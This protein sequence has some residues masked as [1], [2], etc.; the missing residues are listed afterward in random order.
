MIIRK[1]GLRS[2]ANIV[3]SVYVVIGL[4]AGAALTFVGLAG[5]AP[6]DLG[7]I[8]R[9]VFSPVAIFVLPIVSGIKGYIVGA[10]AAWVFN[11]V[12]PLAGGLEIEVE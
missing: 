6:S 11:R 1:V 7:G 10:L 5:L 12:A 2:L 4:I 9:A 3:G 8:E